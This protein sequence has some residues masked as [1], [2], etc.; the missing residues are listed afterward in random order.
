MVTTER[1]VYLYTYE[2]HTPEMYVVE[3]IARGFTLPQLEAVQSAVRMHG[4]M[5]DLLGITA[6]SLRSRANPVCLA[7]ANKECADAYEH[8]Y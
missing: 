3:T 5:F 8:A 4:S 2:K 7:M 1:D 6:N